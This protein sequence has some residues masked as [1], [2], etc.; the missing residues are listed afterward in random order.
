MLPLLYNILLNSDLSNLK[1]QE[2]PEQ[3]E[4]IRCSGEGAPLLEIV[5]KKLPSLKSYWILEELN[6]SQI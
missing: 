4:V 1:Q 6:I 2:L 5:Q 3:L